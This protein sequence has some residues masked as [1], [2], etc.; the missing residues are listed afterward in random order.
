M[1]E[2]I[3]FSMTGG[4]ILF[5]IVYLAMAEGRRRARAE[6]QAENAK[7]QIDAR[8]AMDDATKSKVGKRWRLV[9]WARSRLSS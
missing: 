2:T 8:E 9:E 6:L 4:G 5:A 3:I 7:R 1:I